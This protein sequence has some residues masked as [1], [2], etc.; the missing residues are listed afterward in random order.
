MFATADAECKYWCVIKITLHVGAHDRFVTLPFLLG[1]Y[2]CDKQNLLV[3]ILEL[4]VVLLRG[5]W[6]KSAINLNTSSL[7]S[8]PC[9]GISSVLRLL[10]L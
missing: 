5:P 10:S 6:V 8:H 2:F 1:K 3:G 4:V 9:P 7:P